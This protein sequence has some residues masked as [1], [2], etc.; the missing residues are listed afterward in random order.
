[1]SR[2]ARL[3]PSHEQKQR[4]KHWWVTIAFVGGFVLDVLTLGRVDQLFA[5]ATLGAHVVNAGTSL[6]FLYAA[7]TDKL[8]EGFRRLVLRFAPLLVQFSFGSLLSGTLVFYAQSGSWSVSWPFFVLVLGVMVGNEMVRNRTQ[9]LLFNLAIFFL[10][11]FSYCI[12]FIPVI[13]KSMGAIIFLASG[14][15]ALLMVTGYIRLLRRII[16]NFMEL[17]FRGIVF[18]LGMT[19]VLLNFLYFGNVIPPIP[20]ALKHIDVYHS[21]ARVDGAYVRTYEKAPFWKFWREADTTYHRSTSEPVYCFASVFAP[22]AFSLDIYHQWQY[23]DPEKGWVDHSRIQYPVSGGGEDG[24]RG[25]S[26]I[27]NVREGKWRCIVE[28]KRG[29]ALGQVTFKVVS[30]ESQVPLATVRE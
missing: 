25:Y 17:H 23:K 9:M 15:V 13:L 16:P 10:G 29:Q 27:E 5:M 20:L 3:R 21:V 28:T 26:M 18:S 8:P 12:L 14:G 30:G 19:F 7:A 11:I 4:L 1:M 22:T 2:F 6:A 24:Y